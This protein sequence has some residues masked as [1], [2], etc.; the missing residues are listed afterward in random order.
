M[1]PLRERGEDVVLLAEHFLDAHARRMNKPVPELPPA[2]RRMLAACK[3]PGNVRELENLM[4]RVVLLAGASDIE[5]ILAR[6]P[7]AP[8]PAAADQAGADADLRLQPRVDALERELIGIA[9]ANADDNK[10]KAARALEISERTLWYKLKKF[11][12]RK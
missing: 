5:T 3:W 6:E 9:L 2:A 8:A 12:L 1:P 4:G 11:G 10:A 7:G